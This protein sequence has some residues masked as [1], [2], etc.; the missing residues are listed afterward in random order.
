MRGLQDFT[1]DWRIERRIRDCRTGQQ[2]RFDGRAR[3]APDGAGL[4]YAE[5]GTLC[6]GAAPALAAGRAYLWRQAGPLIDVLFADGRP[7]HSFDPSGAAAAAGHDCA[8]DLYRVAYDFA[9]WPDWH[10]VWEV[11]G[12]RKDYRMDSLFR[13]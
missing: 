6:L 2:G 9:A 7:F 10:A 3:L 12:P 11:R 5:T 4:A 1:G 8:P 13:R